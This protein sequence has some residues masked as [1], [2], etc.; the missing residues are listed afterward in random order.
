[1]DTPNNFDIFKKQGTKL[2]KAIAQYVDI[3]ILNG[4]TCITS[5]QNQITTSNY[6]PRN[7]LSIQ[8]TSSTEEMAIVSTYLNQST[9]NSNWRLCFIHTHHSSWQQLVIYDGDR[10]IQQKVDRVSTKVDLIMQK[11]NQFMI[12]EGKDT[13]LDIIADPKIKTAMIWTSNMIDDLY[14]KQNFQ[15]DAFVYN[16]RTDPNKD[17]DYYVDKEVDK[18]QGSIDRNHFDNIANHESF[19]IIIVYIDQYNKTKFKLIYSPKFDAAMKSI[20]DKEFDQ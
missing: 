10:E 4:N 11:D 7:I 17:P 9:I 20:L 12:A 14:K 1:V 13:F 5:L 8:P 16:L 19:V 18:V 3:L 2:F 6:L 15:F